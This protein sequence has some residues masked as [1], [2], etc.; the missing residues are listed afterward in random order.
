M[1]FIAGFV[2]NPIWIKHTYQYDFCQEDLILNLQ[3]E[4]NKKEEPVVNDA[5]GEKNNKVAE[6]LYYLNAGKVF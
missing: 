5:V 1:I 6:T 3:K 2:A 4:K